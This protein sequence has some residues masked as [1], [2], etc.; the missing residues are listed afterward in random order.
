MQNS[1]RGE[2]RYG[3]FL[4]QSLDAEAGQPATPPPPGP[5]S[6]LANDPNLDR[7]ADIEVMKKQLLASAK[8]RR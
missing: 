3:D 7:T 5:N 8:N 6:N 1:I 4:R 2:N